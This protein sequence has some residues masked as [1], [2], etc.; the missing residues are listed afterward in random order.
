[1]KFSGREI[2]EQKKE[3][4]CGCEEIEGGEEDQGKSDRA[5]GEL[6]GAGKRLAQD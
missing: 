4:Q 5:E 2:L 1:M 6:L 3:E